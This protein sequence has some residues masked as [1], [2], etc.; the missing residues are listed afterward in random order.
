L[1]SGNSGVGAKPSSAGARLDGVALKRVVDHWAA[2]AAEQ[3]SAAF[4]AADHIHP[5]I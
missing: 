5:R 2:A 1:I 4:E 3:K